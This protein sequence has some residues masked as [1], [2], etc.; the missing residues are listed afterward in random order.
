LTANHPGKVFEA[1]VLFERITRYCF[2]H[3]F[4]ILVGGDV[5]TGDIAVKEEH[6]GYKGESSQQIDCL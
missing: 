5:L 4:A 3:V 1:R 6:D 2:P